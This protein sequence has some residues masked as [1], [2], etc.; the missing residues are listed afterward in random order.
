M[1]NCLKLYLFPVL[2]EWDSE[3]LIGPLGLGRTVSSQSL[4]R[5]LERLTREPVGEGLDRRYG[6][7]MEQLLSPMDLRRLGCLNT[8]TKSTG[9]GTGHTSH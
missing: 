6:E 3:V 2:Y 9:V 5:A 8:K 4:T 7:A 1:F